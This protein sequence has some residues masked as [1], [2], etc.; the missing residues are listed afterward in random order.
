MGD[1]NKFQERYL[2]LRQAIVADGVSSNV[3]FQEKDLHTLAKRLECEG[4]SFVLVTLPQLGKA[5]DL[6]LI[7][8]IFSCPASFRLGKGIR[9]P[10]FLLSCFRKIFDDEGV[11]LS[12][13]DVETIRYLRL[14]LLFD[15]KLQ[16][17]PSL[18]LKT[19]T[20]DAFE[21]RMSALRLVRIPTDNDILVRARRLLG[22]ALRHL[23]LSSINP[24]H[25]PGSVAEKLNRFER[26]DFKSWPVKAERY[27]PFQVYGTSSL[28]ALCELGSKL[29]YDRKAITRCCLVP[30][31][32]KG[33]RLISAEGVVNQY[34]QQGQMKK[35][36]QYIHNNR[37]LSRSIK[38]RDQTFNQRLAQQAYDRDLC[39]LDLSNASDTVST[40]LVW[41]LLADVPL[42]RRRLMATRSDYMRYADRLIKITA[43][44]PM[45][46]ATCFPVETLVF[47]A[48]SM[49]CLQ[50]IYP[51]SNAMELSES[52]AVFGDD[53]I[54][55]NAARE[56]LISTLNLVGCSV[57]MSKTCYKTPFRE[58]C[59]SEWYG[60]L[61]V[62]II[63]NRKYS[64]LGSSISDHPALC[65]LQRK[66]FLFGLYRTASLLSSWVNK[67]HPTIQLPVHLLFSDKEKSGL[68]DLRNFTQNRDVGELNRLLSNSRPDFFV[69]S[70]ISYNRFPALLGFYYELNRGSYRY[71]QQLCRYETR[72]P[73]EFQRNQDW[74]T[75]GYPRLMAR[76]LG[77][78]IERIA[79]LHRKMRMAWMSVPPVPS[80]F[81]GA[82]A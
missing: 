1:L 20:V 74:V 40:T 10:L 2:A 71:N 11:I 23:D 4:T 30:K 13:A 37:L 35:I 56:L 7:S 61:D 78:Q 39:T 82:T 49:A 28:K 60:T 64:Y 53:I 52:L 16:T 75:E 73:V 27:Y 46:S 25:G 22:R 36:M 63:R 32:F 33:P 18:E 15:S 68:L 50:N 26:W 48:I 70:S 77:D 24:G 58:S 17:E 47:W 14:F 8:G 79:I 66:C 5:L 72:I 57:N 21:R 59:G 81:R 69:A 67:I 12:D 65:D 80:S 34:L 55:P 43:F 42:L 76:L 38:L 9:L 31:D 45:G 54:I 29:R 51:S 41:Y 6:G 19:E 62:S 3:P 44:A